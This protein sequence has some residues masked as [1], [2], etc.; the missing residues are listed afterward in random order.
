MEIQEDLYRKIVRSMPIVCVDL[1]IRDPAGRTLLLKRNNPPAQDQWWFP[2]GRVHINESFLEAARRKAFQ[3][4]GLTLNKEPIS[5][6]IFELFFDE[7]DAKYHSV[8]NLF[9]IELGE[10]V[11][12]VLDSQSKEFKWVSFA[13]SLSL[14]LHKFVKNILLREFV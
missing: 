11:E 4:C 10:F 7:G 6:G 1:L 9:E 12:I 3:E 5:L 13:E 2:G 8:T 14:D